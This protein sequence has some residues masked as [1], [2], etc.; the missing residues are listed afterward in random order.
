MLEP[1]RKCICCGEVTHSAQPCTC[2]VCGHRMFQTPYDRTDVLR[3]EI[4]KFIRHLEI[5]SI[6]DKTMIF[7][8]QEP[9]GKRQSDGTEAYVEVFKAQDDL[10]FPDFRKIQDF[11]CA[12]GKTETFFDR[13][14][15]TADEIKKHIHSPYAQEYRVSLEPLKA[16]QQNGDFLLRRVLTELGFHAAFPKIDWPEMKLS[17]TEQ[18]NPQLLP[19]AERL[20]SLLPE[21]A[22][23]IRR[24][25]QSNNM[26]GAVF[27]TKPKAGKWLTAN[28]CGKEAFLRCTAEIENVLR[29]TY[30]VDILSDGTEEL[31]EMLRVLWDGVYCLQSPSLLTK[32]YTYRVDGATVVGDAVYDLLLAKIAPHYADIEDALSSGILLGETSESELFALYDRMIALDADGFMGADRDKLITPGESE[33]KLQALI[34]LVE[35]KKIVQKIKA[36]AIANQGTSDLNLH[37]CFSGNPGTGKT[38]VARLIAGI[39]HENKILPTDHVIEVDRGGLVGQYVGETAQKTAEV[40]RAAMGGVLFVD[41]AYALAPK[42]SGYDYGQEAIATLIKAMEDERGKFCVIL[43]GY[44]KEMANLLSQNPGFSS[45]IQFS[46]DFPN[47]SREELGQ[48]LVRML[49]NRQYTISEAAKERILDI[50]DM[51][52]T[53]TDFA[54]ARAVRN[55]LDQVI[56]CQNLRSVGAEDRQI[57]IVDVERYIKDAKISLPRSLRDDGKVLSGEDALEQLVGLESVKRMVRK[58]RAYAKKNKQD[59]DFNLHMCFYGNPGSGKTEVARIISRL[60]YE[61]GVL[62]EAKLVETDAYGLLGSCVGETAP[63]TLNKI[64]EAMGGVLFVDEAYVLSGTNP[65]ESG[66]RSNYADEALTVLLKQM[67]DRRGRFCVIF[68][69]YK[70]EMQN[71]LAAN[72]GLNSRIQFKLDFPDYTR[73][74]LGDIARML[75]QKKGYEITDEALSRILDITDYTRRQPD[76]A[77]ARTLR[78]IL[79]QVILN[80]N[81]RTEDD[82]GDHVIAI[83]DVEAYLEDEAINLHAAPERARTIGFV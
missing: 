15:T 11:V 17:Y 21:L 57:G 58:I 63:K 42:N 1:E 61:A 79:D 10:R 26:F 54:N 24:F 14:H 82:S 44:Q 51:E 78:N 71:M 74:E 19:A 13:L 23:K 70:A 76:F 27:C 37:M 56:L 43:A 73:E 33:K 8:R 28:S 83:S 35:V 48:I 67:E 75:L 3:R 55:I 4:I 9:N 60:L 36:F 65:P 72:P 64:E 22:E 5:T 40:I 12:A 25:I 80:Q 68:A 69:G 46:L 62:E 38:E 32:T 30:V 53:R 20:L 77:N 31:S 34:G 50:T 59:A 49:K 18:P 2:P 52:R 6:D 47:Y 41:E 66:A 29:K 39:L 7:S 16:A 81:L 45:R